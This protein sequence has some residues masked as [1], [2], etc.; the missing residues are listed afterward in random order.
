MGV[1]VTERRV[2]APLRKRQF[3]SLGELNAAIAEQLRLVNTRRFRGQA[4]SRRD[5]FE[6]LEGDAKGR[7][8]KEPG[9]YK[10]TPGIR[11]PFRIAP[12]P[13]V[14]SPRRLGWPAAR[15]LHA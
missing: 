10:D 7:P 6:E 2:L 11:R 5:L 8:V 3:F 12:L 14:R 15:A 9:E 4:I 1:L 13:S